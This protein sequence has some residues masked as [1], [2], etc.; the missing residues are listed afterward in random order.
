MYSSSNQSSAG[1]MQSQNQRWPTPGPIQRPNS[2]SNFN[3]GSPASQFVNYQSYQNSHYQQRPMRNSINQ[4]MSNSSGMSMPQGKS[5]YFNPA[6]AGT[7]CKIAKHSQL[8]LLIYFS[9]FVVKSDG[10]KIPK[11]S[12]P[13]SSP[14]KAPGDSKV[15]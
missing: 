1:S 13:S 3:V 11:S 7:K 8:Y 15:D 2:N 14:T 4:S 6:P 9:F 12:A 10:D 5:Q